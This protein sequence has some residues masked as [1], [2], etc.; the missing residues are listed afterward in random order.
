M[1]NVATVI[2]RVLTD[3]FE[4]PAEAVR[5]QATLDSLDLD[6][7]ALAEFAL[8]LQERLGVKPP[9]DVFAKSSTIAQLSASLEALLDS[10]TTTP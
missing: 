6:S 3:G 4:V 10:G 9:A 7:L 2:H 8:A 1:P 5:P